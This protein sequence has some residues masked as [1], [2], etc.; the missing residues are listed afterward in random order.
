MGSDTPNKL[1]RFSIMSRSPAIASDLS[2]SGM[3]EVSALYSKLIPPC[4]PG[5]RLNSLF[6]K[7]GVKEKLPAIS[8]SP[9]K[10][11]KIINKTASILDFH[12]YS[13]SLAYP[14]GWIQFVSLKGKN[15]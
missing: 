4:K 11:P 7:S 6:K 14:L 3:E 12:I 2:E 8:K 5:P 1:T 13:K 9:A 10:I 15:H